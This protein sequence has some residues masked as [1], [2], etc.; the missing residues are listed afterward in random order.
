[1]PHLFAVLVL[2]GPAHAHAQPARVSAVAFK[3]TLRAPTHRPLATRPWRYVVR[4]TDVQGRPIRAQAR[5]RIVFDGPSAPPP[6]QLG[7]AT[8]RGRYVGTYRWPRAMRGEPLVF[9]AIVTAK[10]ATRTLR[11][12]IRVR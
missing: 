9:R 12:W 7:R 5:F 1:L 4:V 2:A 3:A 10:G 8:F 11:Y 6:R